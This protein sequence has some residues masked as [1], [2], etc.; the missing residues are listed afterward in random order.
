MLIIPTQAVPNQT[1][2]VQ[3][4]NQN[5]V[6]NIYQKGQFDY[7]GLYI[8]LYVNDALIIGGVIS[9]IGKAIV[10]YAYL[11]FV[12]DLAFFDTNTPA[13]VAPY[14]TGLNGR[15]FLAYFAPGELISGV[16]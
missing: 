16:G 5:C 7:A 2:A 13:S 3:L 10:R 1:L 15:Y 11:G 6:I 4:N 12:G 8:D 9:L 14:Y